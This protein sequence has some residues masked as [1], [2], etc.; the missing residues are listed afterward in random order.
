MLN[1]LVDFVLA[2]AHVHSEIYGH[3]TF[4]AST[5]WRDNFEL[6]F[7]AI[8]L[9]GRDNYR[10]LKLFIKFLLLTHDP[11]ADKYQ[12]RKLVF[13]KIAANGLLELKAKYLLCFLGASMPPYTTIKSH[14]HHQ[15]LY[16]FL[17]NSYT[18][19][20][21][22]QWREKPSQ[23]HHFNHHH[24]NHCHQTKFFSWPVLCVDEQCGDIVVHMLYCLL[25]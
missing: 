14:I 17:Q 7:D 23:S 13:K 15:K 18:K 25:Q 16:L 3:L 6:S 19:Q 9:C 20:D 5:S 10:Y 2:Q 8:M 12:K 24:H 4:G 11:M 21:R 22:L 1:P